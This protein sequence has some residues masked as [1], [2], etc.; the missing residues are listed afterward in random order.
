MA[1]PLS[2]VASIIVVVGMGGQI[3]KAVKKLASL[4]G[5]LDSILTLDNEISD[6]HL[7]VLAIFQRH[8]TSGISFPG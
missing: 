1:D 6:L 2:L 7:V 8:R 4:K 3:A 5:A